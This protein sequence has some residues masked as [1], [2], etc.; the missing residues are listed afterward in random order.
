MVPC[1]CTPWC[2]IFFSGSMIVEKE[3]NDCRIR[4]LELLS[5]IRTTQLSNAEVKALENEYNALKTKY[6]KLLLQTK[7]NERKKGR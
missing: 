5:K 3:M 7:L 1:I 4:M 2:T 6:S